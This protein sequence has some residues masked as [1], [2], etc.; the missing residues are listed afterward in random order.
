LL[1]TVGNVLAYTDTSAPRGA[2]SYY[3]VVAVNAAGQSPAS[4]EASARSR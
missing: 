1:A 3:T 2:I 4:G